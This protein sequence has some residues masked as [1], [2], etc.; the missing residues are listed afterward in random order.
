MQHWKLQKGTKKKKKKERKEPKK[1]K[2]LF[3]FMFGFDEK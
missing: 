2:S 1:K 3:T